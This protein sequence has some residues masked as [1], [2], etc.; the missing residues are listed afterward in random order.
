M[1]IV[2]ESDDGF[3]HVEGSS[4]LIEEIDSDDDVSGKDNAEGDN[5]GDG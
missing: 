5:T 3:G 4:V 2:G 1:T